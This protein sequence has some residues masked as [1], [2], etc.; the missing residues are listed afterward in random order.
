VSTPGLSTIQKWYY[1]Q[2]AYLLSRMDA[3]KEG[4]GSMLDN[5]VVVFANE[6][7]SGFTHDTDPWPVI[8]AG[9]GAGRF[10]TG[11]F[12][13]YPTAGGGPRLFPGDVAVNAAPSQTQLLTSLCH[14]MGAM[15]PRVGDAAMGPAGPLPALA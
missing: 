3:V 12:V 9:G 8:L 13:N 14:Y 11:R 2:F 15:V 1:E 10:K 5:S 7:V 6:F 4:N